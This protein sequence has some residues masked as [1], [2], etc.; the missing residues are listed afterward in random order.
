MLSAEVNYFTL[1]ERVNLINHN[2]FHRHKERI[3]KRI[4]LQDKYAESGKPDKLYKKYVLDSESI[5]NEVIELL[6]G[7]NSQIIT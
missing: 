4:C 5:A 3:M 1:L 2:Y 6:N 7:Q